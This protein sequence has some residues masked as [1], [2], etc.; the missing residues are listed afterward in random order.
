[1]RR[2]FVCHMLKIP[3]ILSTLPLGHFVAGMGAGALEAV[4]IVT[5]F[6]VVK[7][8]YHE[9][10]VADAG[11]ISVLV[12]LQAQLGLQKSQL[13]YRGPVHAATQIVRQ[14]GILAMCGIGL[15]FEQTL[16]MLSQVE[17][18]GSHTD[19]QFH[20]PGEGHCPC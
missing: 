18:R 6:E 1:M 14:E 4:A 7:I 8:R 17:W 15:S 10:D 2:L 12:R 3:F 9:R 19:S 11:C 16:N 13:V 20:K 5:P